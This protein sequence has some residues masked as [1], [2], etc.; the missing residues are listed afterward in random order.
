ME[1]KLYFVIIKLAL[2]YFSNQGMKGLDFTF[3][4]DVEKLAYTILVQCVALFSLGKQVFSTLVAELLQG[5]QVAGGGKQSKRRRDQQ[6]L[7]SQ[8][9]ASSCDLYEGTRY[10]SVRSLRQ[11]HEES[12]KT[13]Y[14]GIKNAKL[15]EYFMMN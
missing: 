2:I 11:K 4:T 14:L 3:R 7:I 9:E 12:S 13:K 5:W 6:N 1:K 10:Q 15:D 8:H